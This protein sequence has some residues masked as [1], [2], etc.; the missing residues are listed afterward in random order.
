MLGV[1]KQ[2]TLQRDTAMG[3]YEVL[4]VRYGTRSTSA[5]QVYLNWFVYGEP[6]F[7]LEMDYFFWLVRGAGRVILVDTGFAPA[8]G[9]R[10]GRT[11][12]VPPVEALRRLGVQPAAVDTVVVTHGHYDHTGNVSAFPGADVVMSGRELDFWA[13][14]YA[15]RA[16]FAHSAERPEIEHLVR[17]DGEGLLRRVSGRAEVAPG[18]TVREVGGHTPGQ[19]V[20]EVDAERNPVVLTSDAVHYYEELE[21][22]R[23]FVV[24]ADLAGM[25][26]AFD[27]VGELA[28]T[29][30]TAL[31][32][33]HDPLVM[34]RFPPADGSAGDLAVRVG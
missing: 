30:G 3:N 32:A 18:V 33:G 21:R 14:P 16:Q 4:A 6:D 27:T 8:A 23:P 12:I 1:T 17:L 34:Q 25:Y 10:R 11:T 26:A 2:A 19:L 29:H 31:V 9:D 13:G 20:A 24:V 5:S 22:D 7:P 28:A 15:S